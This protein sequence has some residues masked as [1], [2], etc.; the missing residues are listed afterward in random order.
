MKITTTE[1][2]VIHFECSNCYYIWAPRKNKPKT[3]PRCKIRLDYPTKE[4]WDKIRLRKQQE[5]DINES[6]NRTEN[7]Q[8]NQES[9]DR[10]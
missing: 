1:K 7:K 5:V 3:C 10:L 4:Q 9:T 2:N 6:T 8:S